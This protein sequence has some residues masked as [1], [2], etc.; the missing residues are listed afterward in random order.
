MTVCEC[1]RTHV[2][3][4]DG[5]LRHVAGNTVNDLILRGWKV[6]VNPKRNYYP[7]YDRTHPSYRD[8]QLV[9]F[10]EDTDTL[11]VEKL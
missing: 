4:T 9:D 8:E 3:A 2:I 10:N 7:E 11:I 1:N 6:V 5:G